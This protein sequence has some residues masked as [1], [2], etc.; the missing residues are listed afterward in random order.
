MAAAEIVAQ[1]VIEHEPSEAAAEL[2]QVSRSLPTR[3]R[4]RPGSTLAAKAAT[5]YVYVAQDMRRIL[6]VAAVLFGTL[7]ILWLILVVFRIIQLPFY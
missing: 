5:E 2:E 1:D 6:L 4:V 3:A 7:V